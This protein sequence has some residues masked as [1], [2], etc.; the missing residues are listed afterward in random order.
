MFNNLEAEIRRKG[1]SRV[2]LAAKLG[3][4]PSTISFKLNGKTPFT[5]PEARMLKSIL[6]VDIPLDE[7]FATSE[8]TSKTS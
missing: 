6:E 8:D 4:N 7:L 3:C 1:L 2:S 5:L